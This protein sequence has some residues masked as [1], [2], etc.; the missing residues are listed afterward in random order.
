MIR[1]LRTAASGMEAQQLN[2]DVIANNLANV[3][4]VG[5]KR[6]RAEFQDLFYE[7]IRSARD[8][9]RLVSI[10][11]S[12]TSRC[13]SMH[14]SRSEQVRKLLETCENFE[15]I[16]KFLQKFS[17]RFNSIDAASKGRGRP[18]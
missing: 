4:T 18:P 14:P 10:L 2:I 6:S 12:N 16:M 8:S 13:T 11:R 15:R 17:Q 1:S 5:F 7:E 3:N 9:H